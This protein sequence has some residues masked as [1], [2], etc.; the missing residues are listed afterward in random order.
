M[1]WIGA[2]CIILATTWSGFEASRLLRERTK[3]LR[4]LKMALQSLEAEI[5]YGHTPLIDASLRLSQQLSRPLSWLFESFAQKL[6][7]GTMNARQAWEE[8][9]HEVWKMTALKEGELEIMKQFGE[10]LGQYDHEIQQ[11]Y[12]RLT[13]VH[14]EREEGDAI[15]KQQRYEKMMKSLGVLTGI[16]IVLLLI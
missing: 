7:K 14:L 2:V 11:N 3:Q 6:Q 9:L 16:L 8:S 15:E 5:M 4:Q 13:M 12:I 10:T 1:K